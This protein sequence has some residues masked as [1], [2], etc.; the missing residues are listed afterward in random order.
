MDKR[1][2]RSGEERRGGREDVNLMGKWI[3]HSPIGVLGKGTDR[4][5]TTQRK[6]DR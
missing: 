1:N 6:E 2:R 4:R 3:I 5:T